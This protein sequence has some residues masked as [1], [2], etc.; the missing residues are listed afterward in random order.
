MTRVSDLSAV[1][2]EI[3]D[4]MDNLP[5]C[6]LKSLVCAPQLDKWSMN[7]PRERPTMELITDNYRTAAIIVGC[8]M[9]SWAIV[10]Y[11]ARQEGGDSGSLPQFQLNGP[12]N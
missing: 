6:L 4:D 12:I 2:E 8:K 9:V 5:A 3:S 7:E 1:Q 11:A 10:V